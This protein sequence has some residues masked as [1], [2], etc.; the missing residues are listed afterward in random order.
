MHIF[1]II[2]RKLFKH[3]LG[4]LS[5]LW[6]QPYYFL[7][8]LPF[9]DHFIFLYVGRPTTLAEM[10]KKTE[11][12]LIR[13]YW[14][15][16]FPR[17]VL[18]NVVFIGG[19][20]CKPAKPLPKVNKCPFVHSCTVMFSV[21]MVLHHSFSSLSEKDVGNEVLSLANEKDKFFFTG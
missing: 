19:H 8:S 18:P 4:N 10:M 2:E 11:M 21:E 1:Y 6:R 9:P 14:D 5:I 17:P 3:F 16:E 20:H 13:S 7:S 12:W 15:L